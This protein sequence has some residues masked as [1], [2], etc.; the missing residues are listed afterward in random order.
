M[1]MIHILFPK[2]FRSIGQSMYSSSTSGFGSVLGVMISG[3]LWSTQGAQAFLY[4]SGA[5][6]LAFLIS[7]F[8]NPVKAGEVRD[9]QP[10]FQD[11]R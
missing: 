11:L 8:L 3:S 7:L 1:R 2:G 4:S 5:A 10:S 9:P 6:I